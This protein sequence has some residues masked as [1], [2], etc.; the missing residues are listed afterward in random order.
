MSTQ[1][2]PT[3]NERREEARAAAARMRE[4]QERKAKRQR[5]IAIAV[6]VAVLAVLAVLIA[7]IMAEENRSA[8]EEVELRPQGS[9][10]S[11]AIPV[12]PAGVA[13][14]TEEAPADAVTV[15][16]YS[17]YLCPF[18]ALFEELNDEVLNEMRE[19]GEIVVEYHPVSIL[20]RASA[21]TAYSTRSATAAALVADQAPE[22]F[23]EFNRLLM[24]NQPSETGATPYLTDAEIAALAREAGVPDDVAAR[25][26]SGEYLGQMAD[27]EGRPLTE[28]F[29][30]WVEAA[31]DQASQDLGRLA[32]PTILIDGEVLDV[33]EYNWQQ[34]GELRRAIE[35]ARA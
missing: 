13:G 8:L 33:Q 15:S 26:E 6:I 11:G 3:K 32:T 21:G 31:T 9:T 29:V 4:E 18:C 14:S 19:A 5:T 24:A 34:E 7:Y 12:G 27:G 2:R 1:G 17:D 20:D 22:H 35:D 10:M 23:L 25:I 16:V 28:T 30:P